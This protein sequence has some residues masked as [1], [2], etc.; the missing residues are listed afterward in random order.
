MGKK[1]TLIWTGECRD[2]KLYG[3]LEVEGSIKHNLESEQVVVEYTITFDGDSLTE[4]MQLDTANN[5]KVRMATMR[6][7]PYEELITKR[8]ELNGATVAWKDIPSW[9]TK[10]QKGK[11]KFADMTAQE[12]MSKMTPAQ[13]AAFKALL[14]E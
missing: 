10:G 3:S 5:V 12:I 13:L 14:P 8:E 7:L 2:G 11:K 1:R 6:E 9:T 4:V